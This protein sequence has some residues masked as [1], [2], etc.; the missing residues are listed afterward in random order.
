MLMENR[1]FW[2]WSEE[3]FV[4]TTRDWRS[5]N[6]I[7]CGIDVGSVSS[8]AVV[9]L[10]GMLYAYSVVRTSINSSESAKKAFMPIEDITGLKITDCNFIVGTGYGRVNVTF[11][12]KTIT[13]IACHGKGAYYAGGS[14]VRTI[15]DMGG[16]D[17]KAIHIDSEGK[18]TNFLMNDKCAAGTGRGLEVIAEL[19]EVPIEEIGPR[20]FD[21]DEEPEPV[22]NVCVVFA[23][24]EAY[25]LLKKGWSKNKVLAAYCRAIAERVCSLIKRIGVEPDFFVSGGISKNIGIVKRVERILGIEAVKSSVDAQ[26]IGALGAAIFAKVLYERSKEQGV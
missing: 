11:A 16:Q 4:D 12:N 17:C 19:L 15:L 6:I 5:A 20:S 10:D 21:I 22:S 26:I 14:T 13:E 18:V 25:N 3:V 8:K 1:E 24:T 7:S 9:M 2:R 23:R